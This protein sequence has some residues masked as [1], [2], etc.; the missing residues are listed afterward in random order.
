MTAMALAYRDLADIDD[1]APLDEQDT[2]CLA[3]IREVLV[4]RGKLDRFGVSLLHS[5]FFIGED[6]VL[7]ESCDHD[8]RTL[9]MTVEP[10][11]ALASPNL[12]QTAWRLSDGETMA[13][14]YSA[15][16]MA[17]NSHKRRHV[18]R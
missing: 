14:C 18:E 3:E 9:T 2:A 5:H 4:R 8:G 11:E 6:E 16:V 7:V 1:V 17:N 13:A 10:K 15:C 12:V